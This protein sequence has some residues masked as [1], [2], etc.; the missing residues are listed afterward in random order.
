MPIFYSLIKKI[1]KSASWQ[2]ARL[3]CG[4][5]SWVSERPAD[6]QHP[7][8]C[9]SLENEGLRGQRGLCHPLMLRASVLGVCPG[10]AGLGTAIPHCS[11]CPPSFHWVA[12]K[13]KHHT[14]TEHG[15]DP[16]RAFLEA[17]ADYSCWAL[18]VYSRSY[19]CFHIQVKDKDISHLSTQTPAALSSSS[20][21][22]PTSHV[23][24]AVA[25]SY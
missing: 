14:N 20:P 3:T 8:Y 11:L 17:S 23:L 25:P 10:S 1:N 2:I 12:W 7:Q 13:R 22:F 21:L 18:M 24:P 5:S 9:V 4:L 16:S 6:T 15:T 19:L